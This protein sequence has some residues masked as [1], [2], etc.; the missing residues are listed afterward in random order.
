MEN[1]GGSLLNEVASG[2]L[3]HDTLQREIAVINFLGMDFRKKFITDDYF[4]VLKKQFD[5]VLIAS[6]SSESFDKYRGELDEYQINGSNIFITGNA[7]KSTRLYIKRAAQGKE[8]AH[9]INRFLGGNFTPKIKFNSKFGR[10]AE[11]ENLEY[12]K[13]VSSNPQDKLVE[14]ITTETIEKEAAWCMHCECRKTKN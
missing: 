3:S 6:G 12:L 4:L 11:I 9:Q 7:L 2:K 14:N 1:P 10:L 8:A 5:A 13:G